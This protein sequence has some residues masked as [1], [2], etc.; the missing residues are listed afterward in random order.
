M[1]SRSIFSLFQVIDFGSSCFTNEKIFTYIQS[2]FYRAP[3]V[4]LEADY[5]TEIDMWSLGCIAAE[6]FNGYPIFPGESEVDQFNYFLQYLGLPNPEVYVSAPKK[7]L[8][9]NDDN[10]PISA[11]NSNGIIR[12]PNTENISD[13]LNGASKKFVQ[14]IKV[15]F[16][17]ISNVYYGKRRKE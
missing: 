17:N 13:F 10:T 2:R 16:L 4:I 1:K 14:F 8:F 5:N 12:A 7:L 3:E 11:I 6:L 9:F 15:H